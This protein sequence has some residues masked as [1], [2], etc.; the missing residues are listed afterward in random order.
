MSP[1]TQSL[2]V[3]MIDGFLLPEGIR[4]GTA[5]AS[6]SG[7]TFPVVLTGLQNYVAKVATV[8]A[9]DAVLHCGKFCHNNSPVHVVHMV[10][11]VPNCHEYL[12]SNLNI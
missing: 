7:N 9:V 8:S 1:R 11:G 12:C 2:T 10:E 3:L 5:K 6:A 4:P